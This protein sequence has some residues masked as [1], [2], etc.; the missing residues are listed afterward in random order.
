ML[1]AKTKGLCPD[2]GVGSGRA[3]AMMLGNSSKSSE[4]E[5]D[6][7]P[8]LEPTP[9]VPSPCMSRLM[10]PILPE[11]NNERAPTPYHPHKHIPSW[12]P[13]NMETHLREREGHAAQFLFVLGLGP[14]FQHRHTHFI[15]VH[16]YCIFYKLKVCG[17]PVLSKSVSAII[18]TGL[19][20]G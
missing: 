12:A 9:L 14:I 16:R 17:K 8:S 20:D 11:A 3:G 13:C 18:S 2:L 4:D 6:C 1:G 7:G 10:D 15:A 19:H 5:L